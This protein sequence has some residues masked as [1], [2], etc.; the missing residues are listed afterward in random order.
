V[1]ATLFSGGKAFGE[2]LV[3]LVVTVV[4]ALAAWGFLVR[5][6]PGRRI[7]EGLRGTGHMANRI[8][9]VFNRVGIAAALLVTTTGA[10]VTGFAAGNRYDYETLWRAGEIVEK[11]SSS[12]YAI[13]QY[14]PED[15]PVNYEDRF[16]SPAS[17]AV[18]IASGGLGI[19][20][21]LALVVFGFFRGLGWVVGWF[22]RD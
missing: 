12:G 2:I 14:V 11:P 21:V 19:T 10:M 6:G 9:R 8:I 4:L 1:A 15:F 7:R 18:K 3:G 22:V 13:K 5:A 17:V 20:A 16:P